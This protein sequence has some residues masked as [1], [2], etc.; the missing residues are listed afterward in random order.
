M[1]N[2]LNKTYNGT[3][4]CDTIRDDY[5]FKAKYGS[6]WFCDFLGAQSDGTWRT[7]NGAGTSFGYTQYAPDNK[8]VGELIISTGTTASTFGQ[9]YIGGTGSGGGS[10][11]IF[12]NG[13]F[14]STAR[15][16]VNYLSDATNT[17]NVKVGAMIFLNAF[18]T[19]QGYSFM[20]DPQ[21]TAGYGVT[22]GNWWIIC[23]APSGSVLYDTG[24]AM[25]TAYTKLRV[26]VNASNTQIDF[27]INDNFVYSNTTIFMPNGVVPIHAGIR[28]TVGTTA[29]TLSVD[30]IGYYYNFTTTR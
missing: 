3:E 14:S 17:Y 15:V 23:N 22:N 6:S 25:T 4:W 7:G 16:K 27:Y 12:G 28:K 19:A 24:V 5:N 1:T 2:N 8:T 21:N 13:D 29:A 11:I 30:Y 10:L 26:N 18:S 20:Y 9:V